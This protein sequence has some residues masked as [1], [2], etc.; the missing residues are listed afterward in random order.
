MSNHDTKLTSYRHCSTQWLKPTKSIFKQVRRLPNQI[1]GCDLTFYLRVKFYP[2]TLNKVHDP[3]VLHYLWLQLRRDLK[4]GKLT[5]SMNNLAV[6]VACVLQFEFGNYRLV[7]A[8]EATG[9]LRS[10]DVVP[11]QNLIAKDAIVVWRRLKDCKQHEAMLHFLR[12]SITLETYGFHDLYSVTDHQRQRPFLMGFNYR[13]V[14]LIANARIAHQYWWHNI[15]LVTFEGKMLILHV[16]E[17]ETSKVR[18]VRCLMFVLIKSSVPNYSNPSHLQR[19]LFLG[20]KCSS[21][22]ECRE[23]YMRLVEQKYFFT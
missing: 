12:L 11:N 21:R 14:K 16:Y 4:I 5:S 17:S 3:F 15:S 7:G 2:P 8:E 22:D 23:L 6:L 1:H 20:F 13:G 9:K 19:K 10:L 18:T